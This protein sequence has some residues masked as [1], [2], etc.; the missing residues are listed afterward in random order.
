MV[1]SSD[2]QR[3]SNQVLLNLFDDKSLDLG[4]ITRKKNQFIHDLNEKLKFLF[5][6]KSDFL[7][8][9]KSNSDRRNT[10]YFIDKS[11]FLIVSI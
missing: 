2:D 5:R 11:K 6:S 3:V 10:F 1:L 8:S 4:T 9:E 7:I